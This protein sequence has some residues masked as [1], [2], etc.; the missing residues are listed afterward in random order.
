VVQEARK[1]RQ[2]LGQA[3]SQPAQAGNQAAQVTSQL[4]QVPGSTPPRTYPATGGREGNLVADDAAD[5]EVSTATT[6]KRHP[7]APTNTMS[8]YTECARRKTFFTTS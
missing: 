5:A 3:A 2:Q 4:G 1:T 7:T 8:H 6:Q